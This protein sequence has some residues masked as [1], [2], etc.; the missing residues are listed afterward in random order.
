[1]FLDND[2]H[3]ILL[4]QRP[5]PL[6]PESLRLFRQAGI[7]TIMHIP[8]CSWHEMEPAR[9]TYNWDVGD[10]VIDLA[11]SANLKSII[12]LYV[13][14]PDW[15]WPYP[16]V[17]P[18]Y[19]GGIDTLFNLP[20][21]AVNCFIPEALAAEIDFLEHACDHYTANDVQCCYAMPYGAERIIPQNMP[22][23]A[24]KLIE[25]VLAR[26]RVFG[27]YSDDLW[28]A[29]HPSPASNKEN[30]GNEHLWAC[31]AAMQQAFPSHTLHRII[32]TFFTLCSFQN[33][34]ADT[35]LWVGA[36]YAANVLKHAQVLGQY[37][38]WGLV[39][40]HTH[41]VF[42]ARQPT[43]QEYADTAAA[44]DLLKG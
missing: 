41:S 8:M 39:M 40:C 18:W 29:F 22:Y 36:E 14:S 35:K 44:V 12:G 38:A 43:P 10:R 13:R 25:V 7:K 27:Q 1:M 17:A 5:N 4:Q 11:R 2:E 37:N 24:E 15:A 28:T 19:N 34:I 26:Q 42:D 21:H 33:D 16:I 20:V 9:G 31:Y 23:V 30:T 3:I 6:T 32:Y